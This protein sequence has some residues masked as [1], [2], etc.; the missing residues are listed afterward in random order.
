MASGSATLEPRR[1]TAVA[2]GVAAAPAARARAPAPARRG[3]AAPAG[4]GCESASAARGVRPCSTSAV[5]SVSLSPAWSSSRAATLTASPKQ[6]PAIS[7]TSPRASATCS[8]RPRRPGEAPRSLPRETMPSSTSCICI[9]GLHAPAAGASNTAIRPSPSVLTTWPPWR[10]TGARQRVD[11][12]RDHR[13]GLGVAQ[14]LEQR[15]AAA[16]VGKQDGAVG[17]SGS[18]RGKCTQR[19]HAL[20]TSRSPAAEPPRQGPARPAAA[21]VAVAITGCPGRCAACPSGSGA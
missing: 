13:G 9:G 16:Q 21:L 14:R 5:T 2:R 17:R 11:A 20:Q 18:C 7:T 6:S 1:R 3:R 8:R 12:V 19:R 15:R 4:R 10:A